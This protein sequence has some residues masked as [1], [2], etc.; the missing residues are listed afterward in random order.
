MSKLLI[1]L[2]IAA[3]AVSVIADNHVLFHRRSNPTTW[4]QGERTAAETP[5]PFVM[6]LKQRNL[7]ELERRFWAASDPMGK[8]YQSFMTIDEINNLVGPRPEEVVQVVGWLVSNGV[9]MKQIINQ[10]DSLRVKATS[11]QVE[12][13]FGVEVYAFSHS[14]TQ[15][16]AHVAVGQVSIPAALKGLVELVVGVSDFPIPTPRVKKQPESVRTGST[17]GPQAISAQTIFSFYGMTQNPKV[18]NTSQGVIEFE[19]QNYDDADMTQFVQSS[20][21]TSINPTANHIIGTND[22]TQPGDESMLDIEWIALAG[23][24]VQNWFW[25]E[26]S[27]AWLYTFT[28]HFMST[29]TVP[30]VIS[31]SYAWSEAN[32][33][34]DGI[35][36]GECQQLGVD[37]IGFVQRVNTEWQKIGLR[38]VSIFVASGDSGVHGRTDG[39]CS[40]P[41]FL[42]DYPSASPYITSVGGTQMNNPVPL[43]ASAQPP[44]CSGYSCVA[45]GQE[46]AVSYDHAN[47][48]SGGGF[49]NVASMPG[50]QAKAVNAYLSSGSVQLPNSTYYNATSRGF[51]DISSFGADILIVMSG[52]VT[53]IGGTSAATPTV[54]GMF[55]IFNDYVMHKTGKPLGFINPLLYQMWADEPLAFND[56][57]VGDNACTEQGCT[58]GCQGFNAAP[59]WDP[60]TGLGSPNFQK[61][62]NY[63]KS[64]F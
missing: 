3:I 29:Q 1:A 13:L 63:I 50:Y 10:G 55:A 16:V 46:V 41:A 5:K 24:N 20:N 59:G 42:P 51:P 14:V 31:I 28:T 32:Q 49:S 26:D 35:G 8:E 44:I 60:V 53:P 48:A 4:V 15:K 23:G 30:N 57:T 38:G 6:G 21:L 40:N 11:A 9:D 17:D 43:P 58:P 64:K 45:S 19:N 33:C 54:A 39:D 7:D 12:R 36:A 61:M 18:Y 62:F 22:P 27:T 37:T 25:I 2:C 47:F 56:I 52:S 34:E